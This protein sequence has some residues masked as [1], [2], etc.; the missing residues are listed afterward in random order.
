MTRR[1]NPD[2]KLRRAMDREVQRSSKRVYKVGI[3]VAKTHR[4]PCGLDVYKDG[5]DA[6]A[7]LNVTAQHRVVVDPATVQER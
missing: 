5:R 6:W 4:G 1:L 2:E 7:H 3:C